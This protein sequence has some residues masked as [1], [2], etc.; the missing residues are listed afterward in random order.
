MLGRGGAQP[1]DDLPRVEF[2]RQ[3]PGESVPT[4][5]PRDRH[6]SRQQLDLHP[7]G[8]LLRVRNVGRRRLLHNG[9][10]CTE[11]IARAG[12]TLQIEGVLVLLVE[13]RSRV[14]SS[15]VSYQDRD[16]EFGSAD[17]SGFIGESPVAWGIRDELARIAQSEAHVLIHGHSGSGKELAARTLHR[18]A[19]Q[20][21]PFVD[22]NAATLPES[23]VDAELFGS[24]KN[25][26][27][28][29]VPLRLGLVGAADGGT[30][31]LDEIGELPESHQAHL[32]RV[33]DQGG[34]YQRLG[35]T[36]TRQ[37]R[38]RLVGVTNRDPDDLKHDLL[39][40]FAARV[41]MPSL[42]ERRSDIPFLTRSILD[43]MRREGGVTAKHSQEQASLEA[44]PRLV[45]ALVRHDYQH[46]VRELERVLRLAV[47][48]SG[49]PYVD[50][51]DRVR[52]EL[53]LPAGTASKAP[54]TEEVE[55]ALEQASGSVTRAAERLGLPSRY[56]LYRLLRKHGLQH[57][58]HE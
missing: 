26:P 48:T 53:C 46:H 13:R 34:N 28:P 22:R 56:A 42:S 50:L 23:L 4:G 27:N 54:T 15:T 32:L 10:A 24:A 38:F 19:H 49:G 9:E 30:L 11:A 3:R 35:E 51:T 2:V 55:A 52:A 31:L 12:D 7:E 47:G 44:H 21:G 29:G 25:Y 41:E 18:L 1:T 5:L 45:D 8:T 14:M 37:S 40:R 6:L 16:F 20:N 57:K 17:A 43:R 36:Q 58:K 39:A 33:L